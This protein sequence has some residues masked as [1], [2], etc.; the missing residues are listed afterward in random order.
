[1]LLGTTCRDVP[2]VYS[3][4]GLVNVLYVTTTFCDGVDSQL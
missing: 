2:A 4:Y 1:M 3:Y